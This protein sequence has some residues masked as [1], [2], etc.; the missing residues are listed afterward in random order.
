MKR[1]FSWLVTVGL[2]LSLCV[3]ALAAESVS[4]WQEYGC[5]SEAECIEVWFGGDEAAYDAEVEQRQARRQWE[6]DMADEIAAFDPDAY[7]SS[8]AC[9]MADYYE[10]K[11]VFMEEWLLETEED[12]RACM[13]EDWLDNQWWDYWDAHETERLRAQ[14]GGVA[15]ETGIMLDGKFIPFPNGKPE[16]T[17]G[18]TMAPCRPLLE[19]LGGTA[20]YEGGTL[21]CR[22]GGVTVRLHPGSA[23]AEITDPSG[24]RT[25]DMGAACYTRGG[26]TYI[27]VRFLA[28][29]LGCDVLWDGRFD[30]AVLLQ[31]DKLIARADSRFTAIN[32]LLTTMARES[33]ENYQTK[34]KLEGQ[35]T[36]LDSIN[37]DKTYRLGADMEILQS[38]TTVQLTAKLKLDGL[39]Q[40]LAGLYA[41]E[42]TL[43]LWGELKDSE[44]EVIYDGEK[45]MLYMKL[46][47]LEVLSYGM[48]ADGTWL[49]MPTATIGEMD[50]ITSVGQL[51]YESVYSAYGGEY[52]YGDPAL[53]YQELEKA[54]E[55]TAAYIGDGCFAKS[56]GYQMLHY[57]EE[58]YRADLAEIYGEEYVDWASEF[59]ALELE[60]K[61]AEDSAVFRVLVQSRDQ[62]GLG[63]VFLV[64]AQG[65]ISPKRVNMELL[66]RLKNQFDLSISYSAVTAAT[67]ETPAAAPPEGEMVIEPYEGYADEAY[68]PDLLPAEPAYMPDMP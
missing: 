44:L 51:L 19:A 68:A 57:G 36:A 9:W 46:P 22:S 31:R 47:A 13:L 67:D 54:V 65:T 37:G 20:A 63:T 32:Q 48:Y 5:A 15:G 40:L 4:L 29:V 14:L 55:E 49:A 21:V 10:T 45:G 7:W 26:D 1:V 33:G 6:A 27:P 38:G 41:D 8:G 53:M 25:E 23:S 17:A 60:L 34:V 58:E 52:A 61:V 12:F 16:V 18:H 43:Q 3:P 64:D 59:D 56:G 24:T 28:G 39:E 30:A 42:T 66:V 62:T 35:L 11:E 2:A 50:Q